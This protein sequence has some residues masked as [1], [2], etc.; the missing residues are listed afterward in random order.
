MKNF[1]TKHLKQ[2]NMTYWQH[3]R[4]AIS[5]AFRLFIGVVAGLIH[6]FF[7]FIFVDTMKKT[8]MNLTKKWDGFQ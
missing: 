1:F 4:R 8:V 6:A 3:F 7:P 5:I 2:V